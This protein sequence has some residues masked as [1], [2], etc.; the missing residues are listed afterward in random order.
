MMKRWFILLII[1]LSGA[2]TWAQSVDWIDRQDTYQAVIGQTLRI[3]IRV[4]N[5]TDKPQTFVIRRAAADL[6]AN[7]KGYF[8]VGDECFDGLVD[9]VT[10]KLDP[11]EVAGNVFFVVEPGL[12]TTS[13]SFRFEVYQKGS[14]QMGL[15]HSF[16]LSVDEKPTRSFVFQTRNLTVHDIYPNPVTD[17]D[18]YLDYRLTDEAV[19]AKVVIHNILGSPVGEYEMLAAETRVKIQSDGLSSGVYFYTIYLDNVGVLTRKLVVRK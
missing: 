17:Q 10:R 15:E 4:R 3:P 8:C 19:K 13:N 9:Q 12:A 2:G 18:G 5:T 7:Q 16:L 14:P 1:L 6:N 11:G